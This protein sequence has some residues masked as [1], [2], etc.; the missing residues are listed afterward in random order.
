MNSFWSISLKILSNIHPALKAITPML[1]AEKMEI[2]KSVY[3]P[4]QECHLEGEFQH[5]E[6]SCIVKI[7]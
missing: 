3:F 7:D 6:K 4:T 5:C 1:I 2:S